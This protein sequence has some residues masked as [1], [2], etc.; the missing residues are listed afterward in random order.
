M[1]IAL[2]AIIMVSISPF[3]RTAVMSW[4]L[5]DRKA[6]LLQNAR[7]GMEVITTN[8]RQAKRICKIPWNLAG[9]YVAV[10]NAYDNQTI[11]FFWNI[12]TNP[13]YVGNT[14]LIHD[15]SLVMCTIDNDTGTASA[16]NCQNSLLAKSL[17]N[18]SIIFRNATGDEVSLPY[19]VD[20][21]DILLNLSDPQGFISDTVVVK[22]TVA[23]RP[24]VRINESA[25]AGMNGQAV[26]LAFNDV[27]TGFSTPSQFSVNKIL[28]QNNRETVWVSDSADNSVSRIYW[29]GSAWAKTR[30]AG[31]SNPQSVVANPNETSGGLEVAY[32]AD[33][34]NNRVCRL[35]WSGSAW[36]TTAISTTI[37]DPTSGNISSF[38]F[39]GPRSVCGGEYYGGRHTIWVA[40]SG[41]N[42]IDKGYYDS[43][44]G[45]YNISNYSIASGANP[46]YL[47]FI[48][49]GSDAGSVFVTLPG[50]NGIAMVEFNNTAGGGNIGVDNATWPMAGF[51]APAAI[52]SNSNTNEVWV[53]DTG[54][55]R[56]IKL[57]F[58]KTVLVNLSGFSAPNKVS[59]APINNQCWVADTGNNQIVR[60]DAEGNEEF[61]VSGF[62]STRAVS[63]RL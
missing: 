51:S 19:R 8:L 41:N 30:I 9:D 4:N 55:N 60:L 44:S 3:A 58:D 23:L 11:V 25:W 18:F 27:V 24:S 13:Y 59:A 26:E 36:T 52:S 53:A 49:A 37:T 32:V 10:R 28:F 42:Y 40:D 6:E 31:F 5:G 12:A 62:T 47:T 45:Y 22:S 34:G 21:M 56:I 29:T 14:G 33:T 7:V 2:L 48:N 50:T 43:A 38:S 46:G 63:E 17:S 15:N 1:T 16:A 57:A 54:H 61:R 39:N 20:A 35:T